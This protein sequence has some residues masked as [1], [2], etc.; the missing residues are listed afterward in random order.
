MAFCAD[1]SFAA[2]QVHP[3]AIPRQGFAGKS[4]PRGWIFSISIRHIFNA[5]QIVR[6]SDLRGF[7]DRLFCVMNK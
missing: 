6:F 7:T 3:A 5:A 1:C 2:K 4:P